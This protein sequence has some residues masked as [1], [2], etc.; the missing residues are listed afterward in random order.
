M[1]G[2][3]GPAAAPKPAVAAIWQKRAPAALTSGGNRTTPAWAP[4]SSRSREE[5]AP[6]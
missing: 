5:L 6:G 4:G 2:S 1:A 3:D